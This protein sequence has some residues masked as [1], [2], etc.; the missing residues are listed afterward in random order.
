MEQGRAA[1][2]TPAGIGASFGL[3]SG[4]PVVTIG[5]KRGGAILRTAAP[6]ALS[7]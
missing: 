6:T 5:S 1:P 4:W 7:R 3:S 2:E